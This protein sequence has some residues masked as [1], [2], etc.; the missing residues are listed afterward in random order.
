LAHEAAPPF[1]PL[2]LCDPTLL[3]SIAK[4]VKIRVT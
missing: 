2:R 3:P 4:H 1:V